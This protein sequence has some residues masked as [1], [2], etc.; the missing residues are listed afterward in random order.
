[1]IP[2]NNPTPK[3]LAYAV[4]VQTGGSFAHMVALH[5][6]LKQIDC[7]WPYIVDTERNFQGS[8]SVSLDPAYKQADY[9]KRAK[10]AD[11]I[12]YDDTYLVYRPD[13]EYKPITQAYVET[14]IKWLG[15]AVTAANG[16]FE[17]NVVIIPITAATH[18]DWYYDYSDEKFLVSEANTLDEDI[19]DG[20]EHSFIPADL[21]PKWLADIEKILLT[22]E[23]ELEAL[24]GE[25]P[26]EPPSSTTT[27]EGTN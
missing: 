19:E 11:L 8:L 2:P 16:R 26:P 24:D 1:M 3:T 20:M 10:N 17:G 9:D 7:G 6:L 5:R 14:L 18:Q 25:E 4:K 12:T 23:E 27:S 22:E 15:K 13:D 21:S